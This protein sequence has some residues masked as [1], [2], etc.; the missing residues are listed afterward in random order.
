MEVVI[1]SSL[2]LAWALPDESSAR[3]DRLLGRLTAQDVLWVP[4]LWWYE[5]AN[6][7]MMAERRR[8]IKEADR[9]ALD[10]LYERL[11]I[12]TDAHLTVNTIQHIQSLALAH[13]LSAYDA[14]Y[15]ELA[16]RK[17]LSLATLDKPLLRALQEMGLESAL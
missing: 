13:R 11:P 16:S 10:Q 15:L 1:D 8:R 6:A 12:R 5:I 9:L 14:T 17:S 4:A 7:L 3:A 2:A